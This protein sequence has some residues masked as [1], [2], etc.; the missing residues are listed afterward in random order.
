M[1]NELTFLTKEA[2]AKDKQIQSFLSAFIPEFKSVNHDRYA[3]K[4]DPDPKERI[5]TSSTP[6]AIPALDPNITLEHRSSDGKILPLPKVSYDWKSPEVTRMPLYLPRSGHTLTSSCFQ[7]DDELHLTM[8]FENES[9]N[10]LPSK[11][12]LEIRDHLGNVVFR[13][14]Q[15]IYYVKLQEKLSTLDSAK[16]YVMTVT[17][18]TGL[19][20]TSEEVTIHN[21]HYDPSQGN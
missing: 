3:T 16:D 13:K 9:S 8:K 4:W 20:K 1:K 5:P 2:E 10:N 19:D 7:R 21:K 15:N 12:Q 17:S 18:I 14:R 6:P 11:I